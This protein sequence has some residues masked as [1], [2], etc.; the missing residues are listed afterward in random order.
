MIKN[1]ELVLNEDKSIYHLKLKTEQIADLIYVVGDQ[2]RV[3]EV[4]KHFDSIE[5]QV[6]NREFKTHTGY[7]G[8]KRVSVI[9]SGIGTDNIDIVLNELDALA[10][11]DL[12]SRTIKKKHKKLNIIRIGTSGSIQK[13]IKIDSLIASSHGLGLDNLLH[14]YSE[15]HLNNDINHHLSDYLDWPKELSNPYIYEANQ[16]LLSKFDSINKGI[17]V[18]A[19]GFYGPQGREIR[20]PFKIK[21]IHQLL[22]NYKY[23][24]FSVCNF[25][26]ET[27]A[28]YGLGKLLGHNCLTVCGIL[29]NRLTKEYSKN[30]KKTIEKLIKTV[31]E[32][33]V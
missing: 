3:Q 27:A 16:Q 8:S 32:N 20:L 12:E 23:H 4:S 5:F 33:T 9:S 18:T 30:P 19:P 2:N 31:I 17:T 6:S 13:N 14:F 24:G 11:I 7:I 22:A 29:A 28:I 15:N 21:N 10:N 1:S 26:M 25:E